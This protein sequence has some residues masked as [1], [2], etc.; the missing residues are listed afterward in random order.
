MLNLFNEIFALLL[1]SLVGV[2]ECNKVFGEIHGKRNVIERY[3]KCILFIN[4]FSYM[5]TVYVFKQPYFVFTNQF[6]LEYAIISIVL[7]YLLPVLWK[8]ISDN[9]SINLKVKKNEK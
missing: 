4:L 3:L 7:A 8:L 2:S 1:P 9:I 5:I 6:T